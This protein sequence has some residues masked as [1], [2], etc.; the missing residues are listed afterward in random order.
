MKSNDQF[1]LK[2]KDAVIH[3]PEGLIGLAECKDFVLIENLNLAPFRQLK[4]VDSF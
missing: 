4:C 1:E 2:A 3:F